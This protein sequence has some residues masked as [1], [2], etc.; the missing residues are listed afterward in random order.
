MRD[1]QQVL[2]DLA[3]RLLPLESAQASWI[4]LKIAV[5]VK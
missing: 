4:W 2:K 1:V 5:I 3:Q